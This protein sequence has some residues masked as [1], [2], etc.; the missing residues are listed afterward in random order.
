MGDRFLEHYYLVFDRINDTP[1][2][3][4][5]IREGRR[6]HRNVHIERSSRSK[7]G[8]TPLRFRDLN[9]RWLGSI[10]RGDLVTMN[11]VS[12]VGVH[13]KSSDS[14]VPQQSAKARPSAKGPSWIALIIHFYT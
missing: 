12:A 11:A 8:S 14:R 1:Q 4:R 10:V 13:Y 9:P 2:P 3:A 6:F 5:G 7:L